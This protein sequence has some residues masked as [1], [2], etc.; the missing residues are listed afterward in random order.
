MLAQSTSAIRILFTH[1]PSIRQ[2]LRAVHD[3]HQIPNDR[4]I[5]GHIREYAGSVRDIVSTPEFG[6]HGPIDRCKRVY[7]FDYS[8]LLCRLFAEDGV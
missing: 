8:F 4:T 5:N 3:Y 2:I 6:R 7:D 1:R